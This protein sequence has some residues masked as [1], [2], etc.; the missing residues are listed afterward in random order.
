M[1]INLNT[2]RPRRI[3]RRVSST[4][5]VSVDTRPGSH[6]LYLPAGLKLWGFR[7][8]GFAGVPR[9]GR[10]L[11]VKKTG[12]AGWVVAVGC[13]TF[14]Q[15]VET[16]VPPCERPS[17]R[18]GSD[19]TLSSGDGRYELTLVRR[20]DAVDIASARGVLT[21]Y[22]QV[23]GLD[24]LGDAS[25]PLFGSADVNLSA[26][27]A[28]RT[29]DARSDDPHAPGVLVLEFDRAGAR[30]ILLRFGSSANRRDTVLFDGAYT[31]LE[32]GEI[33]VRGF[34]GSWRSGSDSARGGGYFCAARS[35]LHK[36]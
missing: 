22:P 24:A 23:P 16:V 9:V 35:P 33:S 26:V 28:A 36:P 32:V 14:G 5:R 2:C 31:V 25:T 11:S 15:P 30:T 4:P 3:E 27:G 17:G 6:N 19:A 21:L 18:L 10:D 7:C 12:W 13:S 34:S 8:D 20:I 29:G 1:Y